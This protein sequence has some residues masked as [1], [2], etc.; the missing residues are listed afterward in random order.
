MAAMSEQT[1]TYQMWQHCPGVIAV[2]LHQRLCWQSRGGGIT[3]TAPEPIY[4]L[5]GEMP[6][7]PA[8]QL[9]LVEGLQQSV[10]DVYRSLEGVVK[11]WWAAERANE[12]ALMV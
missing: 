9:R 7:A 12:E 1:P 11:A 10:V 2:R 8:D 4:L 3:Q 5:A 6:S